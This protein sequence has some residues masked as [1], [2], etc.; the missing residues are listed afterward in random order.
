MKWVTRSNVKVDRVAC[1]WLIQR[2]VDPEAEFLFVPEEKLLETARQQNATPFDAPRLAEVRLNHRGE[3]CTFEAILEDYK[4]TQPALH[5]LGLIVRAAD[6]K[7]REHAAAEG[8]GLRAV[9]EGFARMGISDEE[10]LARQFPLYDALYEYA[11]Q[12]AG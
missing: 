2:F 8:L 6:V 5:R 1:P 10:R 3:R 9:A 7:G 4:L 12:Q 11:R